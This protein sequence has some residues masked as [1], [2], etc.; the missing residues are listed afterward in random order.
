[1]LLGRRV[2]DQPIGHRRVIEKAVS[3]LGILRAAPG[4][5][6]EHVSVERPSAEML[7]ERGA[8]QEVDR[9]RARL[10]FGVEQ[11]AELV[12]PAGLAGRQLHAEQ[13]RSLGARRLIVEKAVLAE[14]RDVA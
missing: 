4:E 5:D 14:Q 6:A 10:E 8:E 7:R 1:M 9:S 3:Q 12:D 13:E 2:T 11:F